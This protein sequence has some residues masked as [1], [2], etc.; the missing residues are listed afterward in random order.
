MGLPSCRGG[1]LRGLL[2][3]CGEGCPPLEGARMF[4]V[5]RGEVWVETDTSVL[6]W[7]GRKLRDQGTAKQALATLALRWSSR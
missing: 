1:A 6:K 2:D 3:A 7:D 4:A 5:E